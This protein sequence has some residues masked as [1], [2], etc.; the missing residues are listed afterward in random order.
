MLVRLKLTRIL[1]VTTRID[2]PYSSNELQLLGWFSLSHKHNISIGS[3]CVSEDSHDIGV[4]INF[5]VMFIL[6]FI[7]SEDIVDISLKCSLIGR[8]PFVYANASH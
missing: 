7:F 6:M 1:V 3:L 5:L 2:R 4:S 8:T